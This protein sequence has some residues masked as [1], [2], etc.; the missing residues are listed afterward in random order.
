MHREGH[1]PRKRPRGRGPRDKKGVCL[2]E[3]P[4]FYIHRRIGKLFVSLRHL[5]VGQRRLAS[6]AQVHG[7]KALIDEP[8]VVERLEYPPDTFSVGGVHRTVIIVHVHPPSHALDVCAPFIRIL[9]H[10]LFRFRIEF[11]DAVVLDIFF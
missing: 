10:R 11:F 9:H 6:G 1:V 8:F 5:E 2:R 4:E 7:L 3:K